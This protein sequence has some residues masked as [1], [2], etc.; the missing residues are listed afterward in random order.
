MGIRGAPGVG[1]VP[2]M[3][4]RPCV[5]WPRIICGHTNDNARRGPVAHVECRTMADGGWP[6]LVNGDECDDARDRAEPETVRRSR[7]TKPRVTRTG[8]SSVSPNSPH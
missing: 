1:P 5:G 3:K 6:G 4:I 8:A 2:K 7:Q